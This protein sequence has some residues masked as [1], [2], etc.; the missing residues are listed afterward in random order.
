MSP[1]WGVWSGPDLGHGRRLVAVDRSVLREAHD[2]EGLLAGRS[3]AAE[4]ELALDLQHLLD[5]LD[6][7]GDADRVDDLGAGEVQEQDLVA[8]VEELVA[9]LGDLLAPLVVAVTLGVDHRQPIAAI[10]GYAERL[11]HRL[12]PAFIASYS[13]RRSSRRR[14]TVSPPRP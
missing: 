8:V 9:R 10:H 1:T 6:Q 2:M 3:Q 13:S 7:D 5:D 12:A 11:G 14:Q 4:A